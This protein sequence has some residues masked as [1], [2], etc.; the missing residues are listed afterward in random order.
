VSRL[1]VHVFH[2][3][4]VDEAGATVDLLHVVGTNVSGKTTVR[5]CAIL[6]PLG[7][8]IYSE[9]PEPDY[10]VDLEK[11]AQCGDFFD[12]RKLAGRLKEEGYSGK[13]RLVAMF[14]EAGGPLIANSITLHIAP[15]DRS[16]P[17]LFDVDRWL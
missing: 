1:D 5:G 9:P 10:P 16:D 11:G 12:C 4:R 3:Q 14:L 8:R 17:F 15:E 2:T 7:L 6:L 13:V